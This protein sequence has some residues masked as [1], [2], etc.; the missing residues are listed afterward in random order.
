MRDTNPWKEFPCIPD[1]IFFLCRVVIMGRNPGEQCDDDPGS[2]SSDWKDVFESEKPQEHAEAEE[3]ETAIQKTP[4][5]PKGLIVI[6][7]EPEHFAVED[8][9]KK[10][11]GK[12]HTVKDLPKDDLFADLFG[13]SAPQEEEFQEIRF[14]QS[15][16]R[17]KD[18]KMMY[19]A[20]VPSFS[21]IV[22]TFWLEILVGM[23]LLGFFGILLLA[24]MARRRRLN[25]QQQYVPQVLHVN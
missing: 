18:G 1:I 3:Q 14:V 21:S 8:P 13:L 15:G 2:G 24:N 4:E 6:E 20:V 23:L 11:R 19:V 10:R 17:L 5:H 22:N 25:R 9:K 7:D 16:R 12:I